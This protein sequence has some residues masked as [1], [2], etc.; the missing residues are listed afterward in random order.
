MTIDSPIS[1]AAGISKEV[2][3]HGTLAAALTLNHD[4]PERRYELWE[5]TWPSMDDFDSSLP[6]AWTPELREFL[7]EAAQGRRDLDP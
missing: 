4:S 5:A 3:V 6:L 1:K 2:T 7:P